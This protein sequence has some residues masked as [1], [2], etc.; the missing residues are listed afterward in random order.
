M[1]WI[2]IMN[3]FSIWI[4]AVITHVNQRKHHG[5]ILIY[6][7][8]ILEENGTAYLPGAKLEWEYAIINLAL[9]LKLLYAATGHHMAP[10]RSSLL[11]EILGLT[12]QDKFLLFTG[13]VH[14]TKFIRRQVPIFQDV[15][16]HNNHLKKWIHAPNY[17][18]NILKRNIQS[19]ETGR[20]Y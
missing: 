16:S 1:F 6:L 5:Y 9:V 18:W 7:V 11:T 13:L 14:L 17:K 8:Q 10:N 12:Y 3:Y 19:K 20:G 4:E 2:L 15:Q